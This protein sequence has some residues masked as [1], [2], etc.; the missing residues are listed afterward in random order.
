[1]VPGGF[2]ERLGS[3]LTAWEWFWLLPELL[4]RRRELLYIRPQ[5]CCSS[6]NAGSSFGF[7]T[8]RRPWELLVVSGNFW[9]HLEWILA[10]PRI[11][12]LAHSA[13]VPVYRNA[14]PALRIVFL[15]CNRQFPRF[16]HSS[17]FLAASGDFSSKLKLKAIARPFAA[18]A[19]ESGR[20]GMSLQ[21]WQC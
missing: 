3:I 5:S 19:L 12:I 20:A 1:M 16:K 17:A 8:P 14:T 18:H 4:S 11:T 15:A 9:E 2:R 7:G 13:A 10:A 6:T 21:L